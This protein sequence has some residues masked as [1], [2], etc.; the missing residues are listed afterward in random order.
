MTSYL[1]LKN[2]PD[3]NIKEGI[4]DHLGGGYYVRRLGFQERL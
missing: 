2:A 1:L 3:L 4:N